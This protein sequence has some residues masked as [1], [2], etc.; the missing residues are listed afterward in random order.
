[1]TGAHPPIGLKEI[2]DSD[3]PSRYCP[4]IKRDWRYPVKKR[5]ATLSDGTTVAIRV[6]RTIAGTVYDEVPSRKRPGAQLMRLDSSMLLVF[7]SQLVPISHPS[8]SYASTDEAGA[9]VALA[10]CVEGAESCIVEAAKWDIPV[11]QC[12]S[13]PETSNEVGS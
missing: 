10:F 8:Y 6:T 5:Q 12:Y 3:Q 1:M 13:L 4:N 11:E 9:D 7:G 2:G